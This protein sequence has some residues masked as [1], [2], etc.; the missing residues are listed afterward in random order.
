MSPIGTIRNKITSAG[1]KGAE[2]I[3]AA[4]VRAT[5]RTGRISYTY[6]EP[7]EDVLKMQ[8]TLSERMHEGESPASVLGAS[9]GSELCINYG[10]SSPGRNRGSLPSCVRYLW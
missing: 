8:E 7:Q 2:Q 3:R 9:W 1:A 5:A 6:E 10:S 4:A